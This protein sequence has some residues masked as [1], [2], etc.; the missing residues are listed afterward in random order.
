MPDARLEVTDA[1][2]RRIV[3]IAKGRSTSA[4]AKP[5]I[6]GWPAARSRATTPRST[7]RTTGSSSAT[8]SSRYGTYVNGEQITERTLVHGDRIRLG[9]TG[10]AEMVFLLA[11]SAAAG[12]ASDDDRRSATCARSR[13]CSTGLRALGS[14]RVLDD[15][16][17]LVLDS[18]IEV[19]GAERG[20]IMLAAADRRAR[21]QD[22]ARPRAR[23]APGQQLRD[24]PQDSRGSLPHRRAAHR[25]RPARRRAGQRAHGHRGA[26]HPQRAVRA[27]AAG[28]L[29]RP[30]RSGRRGA[31]HR[32][33]L[34][35]Q[36]RE[37]LAALEL[38]AR[39]ARDARHRSGGRDRE[40]PALSR[41]DGEGADGAGDADRGRD[42]AGAPAEGRPL[43]RLLPRRGGVAA[44]PLDRR[45][46]LRLR[47]PAGRRVRVR[48]RRR[49]RQ[50]AAG[51]APERDDAGHLRGAGGR[52]R[53]AVADDRAREPGALPARH[54]VALRHADVRRRSSRTA[55]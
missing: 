45:R 25:R 43:G 38:D 37:G 27:A 51:G 53:L 33:A 11:D 54:R 26:R 20:F 19:S 47:R 39:R 21:V 31:P 1:L 49:R 30:G 36:P 42:P 46:L 32:R 18:A 41:D 15:V 48:A 28:A 7:P 44:V 10:G 8:R 29:P 2:G 17:A 14:G 40:R 55:G 12:R 6:C 4:A 34:P 16:L 35:R 13:R 3:P 50:G 52:Q 23:D 24:Q 5:T 22:G 9:R